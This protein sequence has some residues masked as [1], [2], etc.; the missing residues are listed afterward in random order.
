MPHY[1]SSAEAAARLGVSRQ[2]LYAYVSRG[3]LHADN[4]GGQR[5]SRYLAAEVEQLAAQRTRGR[6][7][8]EVAKA[9]LN[10]GLPVL[11]SAITLIEDG[12]LYYRGENAL[13]LAASRGLEEV[14]AHLWQCDAGAA[15]GPLAPAWPATMPALMAHHRGRRA[16]EALLPLFTAASE[17]APTALWQKSAPRQAEGCGALLRLMAA[18]LLGAA[19]DDAPIHLQCARAWGVDAD[20]AELIRMA[21]TLCADHE[22]N[23]SSFTA[24]CI[25]STGASLR[26][27]VV[28]GLAALT[29]GKHG[30][31]T[32]RGEALWDEINDGDIGGKM[33]ERLARGDDLPGF[34]HH[35]YPN[36]DVR[37]MALLARIL[38]GDPR[39]QRIV[40]QAFALV[41]QH[42][43]VDFA[44]VAVRR[45][46]RLPPGAAF[47]LF[48]LGR[49][50]GWIAHGLE[51]RGGENLIRPRAAYIGRRPGGQDRRG[52]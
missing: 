41:G 21:L 14:A 51:Q 1:L 33:R 13:D 3:L 16:E 34:G 37:A 48:A 12:Q 52:V 47:G 7:P 28:G 5:E 10:W 17:D 30:G 2:T 43:S 23:A 22:L 39:P 40:E 9:T 35:L 15:F 25:A 50:A 19:P 45:H 27:A 11:E 4:D 18:C 8:K 26:A 38:P 6:K 44:L 20:G 29:G 24:R 42:P 46:L 36:G 31:T 32:A 49:T